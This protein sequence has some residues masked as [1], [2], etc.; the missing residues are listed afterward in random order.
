MLPSVYC[1]FAYGFS[2]IAQEQFGYL[3]T[4]RQQTNFANTTLRFNAMSCRF[5]ICKVSLLATSYQIPKLFLCYTTEPIRES[6]VHRRECSEISRS[7]Q[8]IGKSVVFSE[9]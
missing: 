3:I 2:S 8:R 6:T 7:H 5:G 1:G 4:R 9:Y